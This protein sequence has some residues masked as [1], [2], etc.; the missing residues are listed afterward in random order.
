M[1]NYRRYGEPPFEIALIHGGPGAPG[2]MAPVARKLFAYGGVLEPF[3]TESS[4]E[5]QVSELKTVLEEEGDPP[6]T[7]IGYSWGA[8]LSF[9]LAARYPYQVKKLILIGCGPFEKR[10]AV[11][12][13]KTRLSR[14]SDSEVSEYYQLVRDLE[15]GFLP[16]LE[17]NGSFKRLGEL[18]TKSDSFDPISYDYETLGYN[19]EIYLG[20]WN[21]AEEFRSSGGFLKLRKDIKS[22]LVVIHGDYDP[23]PVEGVTKVLSET[24]LDFKSIILENCGHKPWMERLAR[25]S[26][27]KVLIEELD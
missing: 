1:K 22:P 13:M 27:Y 3:Q 15:E 21:E 8:M 6:V 14:L 24:T 9:I 4:L 16:E 7:L 19:Y 2:E 5:G 17:K 10:Y 25:D 20:V 12:I 11:D 26:F 18:M 23:H